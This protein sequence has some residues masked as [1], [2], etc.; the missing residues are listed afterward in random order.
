MRLFQKYR[1]LEVNEFLTMFRNAKLQVMERNGSFVEVTLDE[2]KRLSAGNR[3]ETLTAAKTLVAA[4]SGKSYFLSAAAGFTVTLPAPAIGLNFEFIV[5]L[6]PTSNG[7]S[8]VTNGGADIIKG[9]TQESE[10][11]TT[12]DGPTDQNADKLLLED[13]ISVA[14]DYIRIR[15]DGT[16]WFFEAMTAAD[17]ALVPSTT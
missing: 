4:D 15:S 2:L 10:T 17:G 3:Y 12:E 16:S 6:A 7:Y 5:S 8:I 13:N 11:D 14:G 9:L 1:R